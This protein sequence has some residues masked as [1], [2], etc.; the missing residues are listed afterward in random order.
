MNNLNKN[1]LL[2]Y[3]NFNLN[4]DCISYIYY[5]IINHS[6]NTIINYWYS[7]IKYKTNL[8]KKMLSFK[9]FRY[10]NLIYYD[11]FNPDVSITFYRISKVFSIID[12]KSFLLK[13]FTMLNNFFN[14]DINNLYFNTYGFNPYRNISKLSIDIFTNKYINF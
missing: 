7:Y 1:L 12:D 10:N 13:H 2:L 9:T 11:P 5:Y 8:Y 14:I 6:T 4:S 3:Y